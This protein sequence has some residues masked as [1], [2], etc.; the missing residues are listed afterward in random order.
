LAHVADRA[1]DVAVERE[2][3][4]VDVALIALARGLERRQREVEPLVARLGD[5][6]ELFDRDR[7]LF[8]IAP[9]FPRRLGQN[10]AAD[11]HLGGREPPGYPAF[12]VAPGA[13]GS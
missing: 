4:A 10:T 7:D 6:G 11:L 9:F 12:A 1:E 2:L 5:G 3:H 8:G 13:L